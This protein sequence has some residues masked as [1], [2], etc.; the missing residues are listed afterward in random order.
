MVEIDITSWRLRRGS[1]SLIIVVGIVLRIVV[2]CGNERVGVGVKVEIGYF[3]YY[4][5]C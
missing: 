1:Y 4:D 5:E 3:Y 2:G